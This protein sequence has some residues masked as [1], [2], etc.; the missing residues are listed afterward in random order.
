MVCER[1]LITIE[2]LVMPFG[3]NLTPFSNSPSVIPVAA[4]KTSFPETKSFVVRT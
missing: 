3:A 2:L 4:K 1:D